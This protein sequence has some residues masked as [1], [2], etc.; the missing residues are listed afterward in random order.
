MKNLFLIGL[1]LF[2]IIGCESNS[3]EDLNEYKTIDL[4]LKGTKLVEASNQFGI[5]AFRW[6]VNDSAN[7]N[8]L[9]SPLSI[10][11]ALSM[12]WNG[13]EGLTRS[14]MSNVFYISS[15]V[16]DTYNNEQK[17]IRDQLLNADRKVSVDVAN[18]IWYRNTDVIADSFA[19]I[20]VDYYS[21]EISPLNFSDGEQAKQII[22]NWVNEKTHGKIPQIVDEVNDDHYM[23]LINA[24]YFLGD[25]KYAFDE[26]MTE[27]EDFFAEDGSINEVQMMKTKANFAAYLSDNVQMIELP[28]G[29]G[30]YNMVLM[31]PVDDNINGFVS[32]MTAE[33]LNDWIDRMDTLNIQVEMPKFKFDVSYELKNALIYLGM[34]TAFSDNAD[35]SLING[36]GGINISK[37]K[38]KAFIDVNE[39][40]TEAAAVTSV[41]I[42]YTSIEPG[43]NNA[44]VRFDKP[45]IF[46]I[47]EN[48]TNA[49]LFMGKIANSL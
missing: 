26:E 15:E 43:A 38:H 30:H 2:Y 11:Q 19:Q 7:C 16:E 18:S 28:Y 37:V 42:E 14:E 5:D 27:N 49:F 36:R 4:S 25:W 9:I 24:V 21:A 23:F 31:M 41:E 46:A 20:V 32:N 22:N 34:P 39:K 13:A 48:D 33:K 44:I 3:D 8:V 47:R 29:N 12:V 40:G 1:V 35:L 6:I 10:V 17:I 45:F